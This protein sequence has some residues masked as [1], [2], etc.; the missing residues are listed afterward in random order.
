MHFV[1]SA[2]RRLHGIRDHGKSR[3]LF[4]GIEGIGQRMIRMITMTCGW[5][6]DNEPESVREGTK[7]NNCGDK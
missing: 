4:K 5:L 1:N 7:T 2:H 3:G 6:A